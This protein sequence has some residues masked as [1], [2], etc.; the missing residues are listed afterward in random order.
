MRIIF[1]LFFISFLSYS[2]NC[3]QTLIGRVTDFHD[4]SPLAGAVLIVAG[5]EKFAQTDFDGNF[6]IEN[7]CEGNY[8]LQV[9]H[10]ECDTKALQFTIPYNGSLNI[11]LEHHLEEL[12]QVTVKGS[13]AIDY[14]TTQLENRIEKEEIENLSYASLGD[15]L[16]T[17]SGVSSL[18]TGSTV[19][20]PVIQG[21]HSSRVL[22]MNNGV[23]MQD[24]EWGVE[25]APNVDLNTAGSISVIKGASALQ[26]GGDAVGGIVLVEPQRIIRKDSLFGT[27][28]LT[29]SNNGRGGT[30]TS[31]IT[32]TKESGWYGTLQGTLKRFGD[33]ETPDYV[34]SN[35]GLFEKAASF[36]FGLN[37]FTYG[38]EG[39]YSFFNSETGILRA[40]HLGN[41]QDLFN[42]IN[43]D[44]PLVIN[45]FTYSID[46]PK[47][48]TT[49]HLAKAKFFK[50]MSNFGKLEIQY[51]FQFN[52]R[53][54]FD[55]RRGGRG[56]RAAVDLELTTHTLST[57]LSF[58]A[59]SKFKANSGLLVRYQNNF[60]NPETGVRRLIPDYD[61]YDVG[62]YALGKYILNQ[63][64]ILEGGLRYDYN[65]LD[66]DKFY[67]KSLWESRGYDI[68][69]PEIV[70]E[71]FGTQLLTNPV[72]DFHN[73]SGTIGFSYSFLDDYELLTNYSLATR[74][75]NPS[76][77]F[78]EGLHHSAARIEIGDL[79]FNQEVAHKISVA[80]S[81]T[82]GNF[83][84]T[85]NPF[86]NS[87][88][89][90][91]LIE[92]SG[93]EQTIRG[94]FQ[95]WDYKQTDSYLL[96]FDLD[97]K[98][99]LTEQFDYSTKFSFVKG[100]EREGDTPLISMPPANLSSMLQYNNKG[101][102][103][104]RLRLESNY[105]FRQNEFPDTNFEVFLPISE[106]TEILDLSSTP[107]AYHL[108]HL[109]A[110]A[111]FNLFGE[112]D[113]SVG[114]TVNNLFNESYRETL[115]RL[116]FFADD[117]G[118]NIVL[119]IKINY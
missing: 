15:A 16:K 86:L 75:P 108:I 47:Q 69:F 38:F 3:N 7:L 116:R 25:H 88:N 58:D 1:I 61:K 96:G 66:A 105:V 77:L 49:H 27:T 43:S 89:D 111:D 6:R 74:A 51:D 112:N 73:F 8:T 91:L 21:L 29:G 22:I 19:V 95:V 40:S 64:W 34:L 94:G 45:D 102:N 50:R 54:E 114:V 87:I 53:L 48:G 11:R 26:Y 9:S 118:R 56:D 70:V 18:N 115:N 100:Y 20:K 2:Q 5:V 119:R 65:H 46:N 35:T 107:D 109:N 103:N 17:L 59:N 10:P 71:D 32:K 99:K 42:A 92:P 67:R 98:L 83:Q 24:Q 44:R 78:S 113:L 36:R 106:T 57:D 85:V 52:N 23:R 55:V 41:A 13:A 30:L 14:V 80:L 4:G 84:F 93:V 39:Y 76:E 68:D 117:L 33:F 104:L 28:V 110:D 82:S 97:A 79:R 31:T 101:L 63:K 12:D 72:F 90:F 60:A 81:K 37:K 62:V